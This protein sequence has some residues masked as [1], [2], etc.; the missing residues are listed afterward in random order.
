MRPFGD[1]LYLHWMPFTGLYKLDLDKG[2]HRV[3]MAQQ[4]RR[5]SE[6]F[7]SNLCLA[8]YSQYSLP[9]IGLNPLRKKQTCLI[10]SRG[11]NRISAGNIGGVN[12]DLTFINTSMLLS[13]FSAKNQTGFTKSLPIHF[14]VLNTQLACE[15]LIQPYIW[16]RFCG[17]QCEWQADRSLV[18][19]Q[20][21]KLRR[22]A[23]VT[24]PRMAEQYTILNDIIIYCL[25]FK[26]NL[27]YIRKT[28][29]YIH[30]NPK[31]KPGTGKKEVSGTLSQY[32]IQ[33]LASSSFGWK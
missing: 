12:T 19:Q 2:A 20:C 8:L 32:F 15:A 4:S 14:L 29:I 6:G 18:I 22:N 1:S 30:T 10:F 11:S 9:E 3:P 25:S 5:V 27:S 7:F 21:S 26:G 23:I 31:G 16:E 28:K 33:R 24:W 13:L 17:T